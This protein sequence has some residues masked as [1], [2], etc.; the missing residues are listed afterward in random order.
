MEQVRRFAVFIAVLSFI[1]SSAQA[2]ETAARRAQSAGEVSDSSRS[3]GGSSAAD[4]SATANMQEGSVITDDRAGRATRS[5][6]KTNAGG[7]IQ[8]TS[9]GSGSP[10]F[11]SG[12]DG[13][14]R[15]GT[16]NVQ[17]AEMNMAGSPVGNL[18]LNDGKPADVNAEMEKGRQRV[19]APAATRSNQINNNN[20]RQNN[21]LSDQS[22]SSG[23]SK[24]SAGAGKKAGKKQVGKKTKG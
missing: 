9:S 12:K 10:A 1:A 7:L 21:A 19:T 22:L 24:A 11:L 23:K 16:N 6:N 20:R 14:E 4:S 8:E 17:R 15:D 18:R 5:G 2:Q 3:N 13:A